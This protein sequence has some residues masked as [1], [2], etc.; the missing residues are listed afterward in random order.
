MYFGIL[1]SHESSIMYFNCM[2][3]FVF[4]L[5]QTAELKAKSSFNLNPSL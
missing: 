5:S 1:I 3:L 2:L 4:F